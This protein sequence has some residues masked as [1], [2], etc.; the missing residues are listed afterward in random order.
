M[1]RSE[2]VFGVYG[3]VNPLR[4]GL[5][6]FRVFVI[7]VVLLFSVCCEASLGSL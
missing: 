6:M 2:S 3:L 7:I 5:G 4:F 1:L